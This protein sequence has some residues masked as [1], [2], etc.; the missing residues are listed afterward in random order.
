MSRFGLA[1]RLARRELR[2]GVKGFRIFLACL[3]LGVGAIATVQSV[4]SGITAALGED[5]RAILGGDLALRLVFQPATEAE[6][7]YLNATAAA[8]STVVD[9]RGMARAPDGDTTLI[10]LKAVDDAYP[11]YGEVELADG[12]GR[13]I[14]LE[15][16]LA[17]RDGTW[18]AALENTIL[19]RLDL[20]VGDV[21]RVGETD[22]EI[23]ATLEREPDR[24]GGAT[25]TIGPRLMIDRAAL[26]DT[27]LVR[28][29]SMVYW[30][31][32]ISLPRDE[33][34]GA[35]V[36]ALNER[37]PEAGWRIRDYTNAA[38]QLQ[39][40]IGRLAL[41]LT[42]VGL[43]ALLVGGVGVGNAVKAYLDGKIATIA[44]LKCVGATGPL[45][46]R[47]YFAQILVLAGL[48][49]ALGL[50]L[51][52]AA[53]PLIG[54]VVEDLLPVRVELGVYPWA[55]L[56]AA[57]FGLL[58]ALTFSLWPLARAR[59]V[60]AAALFRD[61]VAPARGRPRPVYLAATAA[62]ALALA[63]FAIGTAEQPLFA[64]FFVIGAALSFAAFRGAAWLATRAARAAG[65]PRRPALRL[66][67]T[68]L[69]RPGAPTGTVVLSLGLGLTVLVCVALIEGNMSRLVQDTLPEDAPAFFFVDIQPDQLEPFVETVTAI[70]GV[71]DP[72]SV[73]M[74]RGRIVSARG[75][76]AADAVVD[77]ENAWVLRGDRG[78]TYSDGPP[79]D[80]I[81]LAGG[82]WPE[83]YDG[84]PRVSIYK[85]IAL[86]LGLDVGDSIT[87][88]VLGRDITAEVANIREIDWGS[89]GINF[90]MIF[91]PNP[92]S[93]APHTNLATIDAPPSAE[94]EVLRAV[95]EAFPNVTAVRVRDALDTI[96]GIVAQVGGA[97]RA[98]AAITLVAGTL[99][100][101]GA[102]A[103]GHRRRVYEAVVLKV[104]GATR[105][106]VLRA[107]LIEYG[108][109]GIATAC[110]AAV[111]G[112]AA[113][114]AVLTRI[115]GME[116][117]FLPMSVVV[118]AAV[119]TAITVVFGLI[120]TWSAL[121][122]K[123]APLL[124]NE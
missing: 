38:P 115:M 87:V 9:T 67:L 15:E 97:V 63:G 104:L 11:L 56:N 42:L 32:R 118:T 66:A 62:A 114:W 101:A 90:T 85:D 36:A 100:L 47:T 76:P 84:P 34:V 40:M 54:L 95:T 29:G 99:V 18:G 7:D 46:F 98:V 83:G 105:G 111:V 39:Q 121:G 69:H 65:R 48:G 12:D 3:V 109:L 108:L 82:W 110:I 16:A 112:T 57:V 37:F 79:G 60:P 94:A 2:G 17:R 96:N 55:L 58:T 26:D 5:G 107:Y 74:L 103:A 106:T 44:T 91:S 81:V 119:S 19:E 1:L 122:R 124:R 27:G 52:T 92:L 23:R 88:N 13:P 80:E 50:A 21:L 93:A 51:G 86:A 78:V 8:V 43:T 14:T 25:F 4:A 75:L 20:A 73:P 59:D 72:E 6:L 71:T 10:E 45:V 68:N 77:P 33:D 49:I 102:L 28:P 41:F 53:P 116:W 89:L 61:L 22:F 117:T 24:A 123:A 120:G 113:A 30:N 64:L 35:Y 31:Y 70:P